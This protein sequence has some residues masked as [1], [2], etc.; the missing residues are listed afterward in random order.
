V[1]IVD[2]YKLVIVI[3]KN[4]EAESTWRFPDTIFVERRL[5][6]TNL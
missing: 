1:E 6:V 4:V 2:G 3:C 5:S